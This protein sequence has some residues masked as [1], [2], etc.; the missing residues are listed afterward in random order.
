[1][2]KHHLMPCLLLLLQGFPLKNGRIDVNSPG[3][4][5]E[6][7]LPINTQENGSFEIVFDLL[8]YDPNPESPM[9]E[10]TFT[11][12]DSGILSISP[13]SFEWKNK[14]D[15][16]LAASSDERSN[17]WRARYIGNGSQQMGLLVDGV[18]L[19]DS[20]E[21]VLRIRFGLRWVAVPFEVVV[22]NRTSISPSL[23]ATSDLPLQV[24][25]NGSLMLIFDA[26]GFELDLLNEKQSTFVAPDS[27]MF[28]LVPGD[29]DWKTRDDLMMFVGSASRS[30]NWRV[31]YEGSG[32]KQM[33]M[34]LEGVSLHDSGEWALQIRDATATRWATA[35]FEIVVEQ[36][37]SLSTDTEMPVRVQEGG[38]F[39]V[40]F[41]LSGFEVDLDDNRQ[42][43]MITPDGALFWLTPDSSVW[44]NHTDL[45]LSMNS[46]RRSDNWKIRYSGNGTEQMGLLVESASL[47]D[48]GNWTLTMRNNG[49]TAIADGIIAQFEVVVCCGLTTST[50]L[51]IEVE[52]NGSLEILFNLVG[53][54]L[55]PSEEQTAA[56]FTPD[57]ALMFLSPDEADSEWKKREDLILSMA[58]GLRHHNWRMRR[59]GTGLKQFGMKLEGVSTYDNGNWTL[60]IRENGTESGWVDAKFEVVVNPLPS[61]TTKTDLPVLAD[62]G[63][64]FEIVFDMNGFE[65]DPLNARQT[66]FFTPDKALMY[67][68]PNTT[69]WKDRMDLVMAMTTGMRKSS[70]RMRYV[71][72]GSQQMGVRVEGVSMFDSGNWT[73]TMM[74]ANISV[75]STR[76]EVVVTEEPHLVTDT[77]LPIEVEEEGTVEIVFDLIGFELDPERSHQSG[78]FTPDFAHMWMNPADPTW[79]NRSGLA[80][81]PGSGL[82][83]DEWRMRY[84]GNGNAQMGMRLEGISMHDSGNWS[85][86]VQPP[87]WNMIS[88]SFEI[89]VTEKPYLTTQKDLPIRVQ[90]NGSLD[91]VFDLV[92]FE[93]DLSLQSQT[94]F[95]TPDMALFFVN[96]TDID[97][98]NG[99]DLIL[100]MTSTPRPE[101][102]KV[103][104]EGSG[105][106]Q[107]GLR[108]EGVSEHD[109]GIWRLRIRHNNAWVETS[110]ELIVTEYDL[111]NTG[112]NS[113]I[114][115][116]EGDSFSIVFQLK[117][118]QLTNNTRQSSFVAPDRGIIWLSPYD[119]SWKPTFDIE[120]LL[121]ISVDAHTRPDN[122]RVRYEGNGPGEIGITLEGASFLDSG[123]WSVRVATI[124]HGDHFA[125]ANFQVTVGNSTQIPTKPSLE[126]VVEGPINA[127]VGGTI[128]AVFD[129]VGFE[130]D[131]AVKKQAQ[132]QTPDQA[133]FSLDPNNHSWHDGSI[134][135]LGFQSNPRPSDWRIRYMGSGLQQVGFRLEK[136]SAFDSG[137]WELKIRHG[138]TIVSASFEVMVEST[139]TT[140]TTTATTTMIKTTTT[141]SE[142]TTADSSS[143]CLKHW[144][145]W[146]V[147][148]VSISFSKSL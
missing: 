137:L 38:E 121:P 7:E 81:T 98:K 124:G 83:P 135:A 68:P 17:E 48:N 64:S 146:T 40:I 112:N 61:L 131:P 94:A 78:F 136:L 108:L 125:T 134:L 36:I 69:V 144:T 32:A 50:H 107:M 82:R 23:R 77:V 74:N 100:S 9:Y 62:E 22:D 95:F 140:T 34:L 96:P 141:M 3:L 44:Q 39:E 31:R 12:P 142:I 26:I 76:F 79:K 53:F 89:I 84:S 126:S 138:K 132:F 116:E 52:E 87:N 114:L 122:W 4:T 113:P 90:V 128:E 35:F 57:F 21:W 1:M 15:L 11:T 27:S 106:A 127:Q 129:L 63:G 119:T 29:P 47:F 139:S 97:W 14:T 70:W 115:I 16:G 120:P 28:N 104:Y 2:A 43:M 117:G 10:A 55:H 49:S 88:T 6:T 59:L 20:G 51:P 54:D 65:L 101:N 58:S 80:L 72:T 145:P 24:Q 133:V 56:F 148:I 19:L 66:M 13:G 105:A 33:G 102:W 91:I 147:L 45:V 25:E 93:L 37:P 92:G 67:L 71:G 60:R 5:T 18:S 130:M 118:F 85:L 30:D 41:D 109:A 86:V 103:R 111:T 42:T 8:G 123:E 99:T 73:L 46:G 143:D 110:F 75:V